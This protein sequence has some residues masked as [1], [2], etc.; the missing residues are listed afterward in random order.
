M[1]AA[2][3]ELRAILDAKYA[4]NPYDL[5]VAEAL[6]DN[7]LLERDLYIRTGQAGELLAVSRR[8]VEI[9]KKLA[10]A[11]PA[12]GE[13][14]SL[15][16]SSMNNLSLD[17]WE[18]GLRD[19]SLAVNREGA[20]AA[21]ARLAAPLSQTDARLTLISH[22][23]YLV[24]QFHALDEP[25]EGLRLRL[26]ADSLVEAIVQKDANNQRAFNLLLTALYDSCNNAWANGSLGAGRDLFE[27]VI[28]PWRISRKRTRSRNK[29]SR[30]R[31]DNRSRN[32]P[33]CGRRASGSRSYSSR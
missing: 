1:G 17:L 26:Q 31:K 25:A 19:E 23:G 7:L 8:S 30:T 12:Y 33:A 13:R 10:A 27:S 24:R 28:P 11:Y 21:A 4:E 20:A 3:G 18:A 5:R 6:W 22:M 32:W 14:E 15:W 9:A 2:V 16:Y 29:R